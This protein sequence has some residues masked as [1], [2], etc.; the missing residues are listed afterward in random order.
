M[1]LQSKVSGKLEFKSKVEKEKEKEREREKER[2]KAANAAADMNGGVEDQ[3]AGLGSIGL[4]NLTSPLPISSSPSSSSIS[5]SDPSSSSLIPPLSARPTSDQIAQTS[6]YSPRLRFEQMVPNKKVDYRF[7]GD[8][9]METEEM[10]SIRKGLRKCKE[11]TDWID[12]FWQMYNKETIEIEATPSAPASS[13]TGI[14]RDTYL[15]VHS[16]MFKALHRRFS[17]LE[18]RSAALRDWSRD[19]WLS[20]HPQLLDY[21]AFS[22]GLFEAV[23][24]WCLTIEPL[25]Y[26]HFLAVLFHRIT[27]IK[28][29]YNPLTGDKERSVF[30]W[31]KLKLINSSNVYRSFKYSEYTNLKWK[32]AKEMAKMGILGGWGEEDGEGDEEDEEGDGQGDDGVEEEEEE[33]EEKNETKKQQNSSKP[34]SA[35]TKSKSKSKP[36]AKKTGLE[37]L[38]FVQKSDSNY[39]DDEENDEDD[40]DDDD[41]ESEE[42][43]WTSEESSEEE[44]PM[45]KSISATASPAVSHKILSPKTLK[46][47]ELNATPGKKSPLSSKRGSTINS[48]P[49]QAPLV[50]PSSN[51][52]PSS[53]SASSKSTSAAVSTP[54]PTATTGGRRPRPA[55][56]VVPPSSDDAKKNDE[57][58]LAADD[59]EGN[60]FWNS[61][62]EEYSKLSEQDKARLKELKSALSSAANLV[63]ANKAKNDQVGESGRKKKKNATGDD[64]E[65]DEEYEID[66]TVPLR[67]TKRNQEGKAD[68]NDAAPDAIASSNLS[69]FG[70]ALAS[71]LQPNVSPSSSISPTSTAPSSSSTSDFVTLKAL[72]LFNGDIQAA[73]AAI[74]AG[75]FDKLAKRKNNKNKKEGKGVDDEEDEEGEEEKDFGTEKILTMHS[76]E[77]APSKEEMKENESIDNSGADLKKKKS[78]STSSRTGS[79]SKPHVSSSRPGSSSHSRAPAM[80]GGPRLMNSSNAPSDSESESTSALRRVQRLAA[81]AA[82]GCSSREAARGGTSSSIALA[83]AAAGAKEGGIGYS[84]ALEAAERRR[85]KVLEEKGGEEEEER[86]AMKLMGKKGPIKAVEAAVAAIAAAA[87]AAAAATTSTASTRPSS[88]SHYSAQSHTSSTS[89]DPTSFNEQ[90]AISIAERTILTLLTAAKEESTSPPTRSLPS[91]KPSSETGLK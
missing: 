2:E 63:N 62:D 10:K 82:R 17:S 32:K 1:V 35:D 46:V 5:S 79:L 49:I 59:L 8:L 36:S 7:D 83:A 42:S 23:D 6:M 66:T 9:S 88:S 54:S 31:K 69:S 55:G 84:I 60:E 12:V 70:L 51:L 26:I 57:N 15:H 68:S 74:L 50:P 76:T 3:I 34:S 16:L 48:E 85:K 40:D 39:P 80:G 25:E 67:R 13:I 71:S 53:H 86:E 89:S 91:S 90:D 45:H 4:R 30:V 81:R 41:E 24:L 29:I 77:N 56:P 73:A 58:D 37:H 75:K 72:K 61:D 18:S 22:T 20:S 11:L 44:S 33:K 27:R 28:T 78:P 19:I 87:A 65:S 47:N 64:D 38:N 21:H 14:R 43:S 52:L